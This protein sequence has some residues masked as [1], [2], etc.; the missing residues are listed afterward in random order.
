MVPLSD[1]L[2]VGV[3]GGYDRLAN[4][5]ADSPL[6]KKRGDPNQFMGGLRL[7]YEFGY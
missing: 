5:V 4:G 3:F 6:I 7:S 1:T 2:S